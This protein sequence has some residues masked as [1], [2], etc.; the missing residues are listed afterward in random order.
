MR[1][2]F[3]E[4][5]LFFLPFLKDLY[6]GSNNSSNQKN[7]NASAFYTHVYQ[8]AV[9]TVRDDKKASF[10][11][12]DRGMKSTKICVQQN[13]RLMKQDREMGRISSK[14]GIEGTSFLCCSMHVLTL[15]IFVLY[16]LNGYFF[17]PYCISSELGVN[18]LV[19]Q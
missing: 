13:L 15:V 14:T 8:E 17:S 4:I 6:A 12:T 1:V 5:N 19:S 9:Q 10:K 2:M 18:S 3:M 16:V 11:N 7:R